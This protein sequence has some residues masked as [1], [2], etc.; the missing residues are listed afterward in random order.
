MEKPNSGQG[1]APA[2]EV[3]S[4]PTCPYCHMAKQYLQSKKVA[5]KDIDVSRD[6]AAAQRMMAATGQVGVP[7][8]RINGEWIV[9]FDRPAIDRAL[10][11]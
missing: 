9:G 6:M 11:G 2:V 3:Y 7:Q 4:T 10:V 8:L 5:F 1:G